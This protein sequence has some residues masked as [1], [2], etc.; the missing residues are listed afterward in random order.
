METTQLHHRNTI[1]PFNQHAPTT[2]KKDHQQ[3]LQRVTWLL[4]FAGIGLRLFHFF[5]N[6]SLWTD[7]IYLAVSLIKMNYLELTAPAL[8]YEQKAP[9]GFLW[10]VRTSVLLFGKG[11]MALRLVPLLAGIASLLL[12][13]PLC[14][15]FLKPMGVAVAVGI[16]ALAP[17]L[18]YHAVEIKQYGF[19]MLITILA[20][21]LY[22]RFEHRT[23][24]KALILWG[25][26]GAS[27]YWFSFTAPFVLTSIAMVVGLTHL[28]Q[29]D[30]SRF[31][32]SFIPFLI[33]FVSF[34]LNYFLFTYNHSDSE[35]LVNFFK[36]YGGFMPF[37]PTSAGDA[38][39]FVQT[40]YKL[41]YYPLGLLWNASKIN[42]PI[43]SGL[44]KLP[45]LG[46]V[47]LIAGTISFARG[48]KQWFFILVAPLLLHLVASA[49]ELY[50]FSERF[51]V[52]AAPMLVL[53]IG[54][55]ADAITGLLPKI[56]AWRYALPL[57]VVAGPLAGSAMQLVNPPYFGGYKHSN[58]RDALLLVDQQFKNGDAVYIYWNAIHPYK[59]YKD[60]YNLK[61][62]GILGKDH[63]WKANNTSTYFSSIAADLQQLQGQKRVWI[64]Y[65]NS[66]DINIGDNIT[67]LPPWYVA[68]AKGGAKLRSA[69]GSVGQEIAHQ[70]LGDMGVSLFQ[71]ETTA[72]TGIKVNGTPR[73]TLQEVR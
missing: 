3:L 22:V 40:A 54:R 2:T 32:K 46:M 28:L 45:I 14:R 52:Y 38:N 9:I 16:M 8:D 24:T 17:P 49:L 66:L 56:G 48:N 37:P 64:V 68:E 70:T 21:H 62:D 19:D 35:W 36:Y 63:R 41:L 69:T 15:H 50:P 1:W 55:G 29:K 73:E 60:A 61:Y 20:L 43:W 30:W 23:D 31:F 7:E 59:Y 34:A 57:I 67:Q 11:E 10:L 72:P 44:L 65:N 12:F 5:H 18:I 58:Q 33:W 6:R 47:F 51:V 4:I 53:F 13:L 71:L 39:W 25:L 42:H 26:G 27:L